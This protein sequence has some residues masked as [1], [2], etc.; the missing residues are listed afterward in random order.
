SAVLLQG[1][2]RDG[3]ARGQ[4]RT[5]SGGTSAPRPQVLRPPPSPSQQQAAVE[6]QARGPRC[7]S[8]E[9]RPAAEE[10]PD[11]PIPHRLREPQRSRSES[12]LLRAP[13]DGGV[14]AQAGDGQAARS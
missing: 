10:R 6:D 7:P 9:P 11:V 3:R 14:P 4:E 8:E 13:P 5:E 12:A 2:G 1:A